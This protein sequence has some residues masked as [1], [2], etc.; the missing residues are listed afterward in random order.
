[1]LRSGFLFAAIVGTWLIWSDMLPALGFLERTEL[2]LTTTEVVDGV[3]RETPVT[4]ADL[5]VGLLIGLIT[6]LASR[7]LPG[8]LEILL[9]QRLPL[10]Q[11]ARYAITTLA[12]Y[13]IAGVGIIV[14]FGSIGL[15]PRSP[16]GRGRSCWCP[17]R[18]SS[19]ED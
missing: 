2:P 1:M 6:L 8:V 15:P 5:T 9:L 16:I 7:N 19:P 12:Q 18:S 14:V 3:S 11:G 13:L 10:D 17:T 4:L